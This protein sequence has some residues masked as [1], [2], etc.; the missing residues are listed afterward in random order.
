MVL[1]LTSHKRRTLE[2]RKGEDGQM[3][4]ISQER[5]DSDEM[6]ME[7]I[8]KIDSKHTIGDALRDLRA[9]VVSESRKSYVLGRLGR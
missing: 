8:K 3:K 7:I 2:T 6:I 5:W 4:N 9:Q 1:A